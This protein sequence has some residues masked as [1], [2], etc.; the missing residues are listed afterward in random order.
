MTTATDPF[1]KAAEALSQ[2]S[3]VALACHVNPDG[4]ALGS[5]LG[6]HHALRALRAALE[7]DG[8]VPASGQVVR[9][10]IN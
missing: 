1:A 6:M 10:A 3:A 7:A 4:D 2:A 9:E 5:M 8:R